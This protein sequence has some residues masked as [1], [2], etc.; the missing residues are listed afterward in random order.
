MSKPFSNCSLAD[1]ANEIHLASLDPASSAIDPAVAALVMPS[2]L[3]AELTE[4]VISRHPHVRTGGV[5]VCTADADSKKAWCS[6]L[7]DLLDGTSSNVSDATRLRLYIVFKECAKRGHVRMPEVS[8]AAQSKVVTNQPIDEAVDLSASA[9]DD[10][11]PAQAPRAHDAMVTDAAASPLPTTSKATLLGE[12]DAP[13]SVVDSKSSARTVHVQAPRSYVDADGHID[14]SV[15]QIDRYENLQL[16]G[17]GTFGCV[18]RGW[19]PKHQREVA[20]KVVRRTP[21]YFQDA[22]IE[23]LTITRLQT[24]LNSQDHCV[25]IYRYLEWNEHFCIAFERLH[26]TLHSYIYDKKRRG[27]GCKRNVIQH[28]ILRLLQCVKYLHSVRIAHVDIKPENIMFTEDFRTTGNYSVKLIDFGAATWLTTQHSSLIQTRFYRAP[29]VIIES[30]WDEK[31]DVWS[32]GCIMLEMYLGRLAFDTHD[33]LEH[34]HLIEKLCGPIPQSLLRRSPASCDL[35]QRGPEMCAT[36]PD[37]ALRK[38]SDMKRVR[39]YL[40]SFQSLK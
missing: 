7:S 14:P 15:R 20:L 23:A 30:K 33:S 37:E 21:K 2:F 8:S 26:S 32:V 4:T 11:A 1:L 3:N 28:V 6:L 19:D 16:I 39:Q 27:I 36:T 34:L 10:A 18:F 9:S 25:I 38:I 35:V 22:K 24:E 40:L 31:A 17:K 29:E 12:L 13:N 5:L